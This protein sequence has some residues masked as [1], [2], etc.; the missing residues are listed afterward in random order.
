MLNS[1]EKIV[2]F[3]RIYT[4]ALP[5]LRADA[6][7][8]STLPTAAFQFCE[9][10]RSASSFGWYVFPPT[11]ILLK[12][13]G[14]DVFFSIDG[15]W[16]LLSSAHLDNEFLEYWDQNAPSDLQ[17]R[18]P[19]FLTSLFVPG[20][21][22]I[23]SGFLV[24]TAPGWS[25]KIGP[26]ANMAQSRSFS[27]YEAIVETD[28]FKPCPLFV[29]IRLI[30]TDREIRISK[31]KPLFQVKPLLRECYSEKSLAYNEL[32]GLEPLCDGG[33]MTAED[34]EGY[35]TTVRSVEPVRTADER[36]PGSY[37]ARLRRRRKRSDQRESH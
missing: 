26:V 10:V 28:V 12:W 20:V 24:S 37:G 22:Q 9:P 31:I 3:N 36:N 32:T 2:T 14:S 11:D 16:T 30:S 4:G 19:P 34:W 23:W 33:G 27:C 8:L 35:R 21:V 13:D 18:A 29:N 6:S 25:L 17:G 1:P 7:A 5:L 15:Q